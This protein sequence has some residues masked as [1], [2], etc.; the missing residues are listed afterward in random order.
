MKQTKFEGKTKLKQETKLNWNE[1]K[2]KQKQNV[3]AEK[4]NT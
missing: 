3:T 4:I 1:I 2:L